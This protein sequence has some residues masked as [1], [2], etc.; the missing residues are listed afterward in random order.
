MG[1]TCSRSSPR[2]RGHPSAGSSMSQRPRPSRAGTTRRSPRSSSPATKPSRTPAPADGRG[3]LLDALVAEARLR[4]GLDPADGI[5]VFAAETL[6]G[7]PIEP[8]RPLLIVP[9]ATLRPE[10]TAAEPAPLA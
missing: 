3:P 7:A 1:R 5:Q 9:L 4:W 6:V 8:S 10:A 2:K